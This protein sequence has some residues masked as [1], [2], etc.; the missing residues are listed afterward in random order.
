MAGYGVGEVIQ[1]ILQRR[2]EDARQAMLDQLEREQLGMRQRESEAN[3]TAQQ[4]RT[5]HDE[6]SLGLQREQEQRLKDE[7]LENQMH[8]RL[9]YATPGQPL[10]DPKLSEYAER[11][12]AMAQIPDVQRPDVAQFRAKINDSGEVQTEEFDPTIQGQRVYSGGPELAYREQVNQKTAALLKD[13]NFQ[14]MP[15]IEK[16]IALRGAGLDQVPE[17]AASGP[18]RVVPI[19]WN[20]RTPVELGPSDI[21]MEMNPP[22]SSFFG[23]YGGASGMMPAAARMRNRATGEERT[24]TGPRAQLMTQIDPLEAQGWELVEIKTSGDVGQGTAT[25]PAVQKALSDAKSAWLALEN[26]RYSKAWGSW[27]SDPGLPEQRS[28]QQYESLRDQQFRNDPAPEDIK[29][30]A[31]DIAGTRELR[32][33]N[34]QAIVESLEPEDAAQLD[35]LDK[36]HLQ[37]LLSY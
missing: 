16:F 17:W 11:V 4:A 31:R 35:E 8:R 34:V 3:I 15:P 6:Q 33:L 7:L 28:R 14:N 18:R 26:D 10:S 13:P 24:L 20:Q 22:P 27:V 37:R 29:Q 19:P 30:L 25:A 1:S 12:G 32:G 5:Q 9:Q 21:P 2:R 23:G 36:Q